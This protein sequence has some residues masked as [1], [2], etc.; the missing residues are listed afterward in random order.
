MGNFRHPRI[1]PHDSPQAEKA[2]T[3]RG[4]TG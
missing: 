1:V 3:T 4:T 2:A